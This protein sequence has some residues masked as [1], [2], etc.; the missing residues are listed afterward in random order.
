[1]T[2]RHTFALVDKLRM[3]YRCDCGV[4]GRPRGARIV[5]LACQYELD[6]RKHCGADAVH[7]TGDRQTNRCAAHMPRHQHEPIRKAISFE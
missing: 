2:H 1:M 5:P 7:A 3:R 4:I 6:S